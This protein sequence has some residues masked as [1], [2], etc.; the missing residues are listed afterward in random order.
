M[1]KW[2]PFDK[3]ILNAD[4]DE[5]AGAEDAGY[6]VPRDADSGSDLIPGSAQADVDRE[7]AFSSD[8]S[9]LSGS[10]SLNE[11]MSADAD[12][13]WTGAD[14][15][16][17]S[18]SGFG[19]APE[20]GS[21]ASDLSQAPE[22][23]SPASDLSQAP[24][25]GSPAPDL[26]Q[27][28]EAGSFGAD[29]HQSSKEDGSAPEFSQSQEED[30]FGADSGQAPEEN[31]LVSDF[32]QIPEEGNTAPDYSQPQEAG[33]F[34]ADFGQA[35]EE[36]GSAPDFS[37][38]AEN[39][40]G[41][42]EPAGPDGPGFGPEHD[43]EDDEPK[44]DTQTGERLDKPKKKLP[45]MFLTFAV[46]V[47]AVG[48]FIYSV[49]PG[50]LPSDNDVQPKE[51]VETE[52][53]LAIAEHEE[54]SEK[55]AF[56]QTEPESAEP[57][58]TEG[59]SEA[60]FSTVQSVLKPS[61]TETEIETETETEAGAGLQIFEEGPKFSTDGI[62]VS[63]S[64]DVSDLVEEAMPEV[65]SVT[66]ASVQRVWDF[67]SGE[68]EIVQSEAGSGIIIGRDEDYLYIVT[69]GVI[70]AGAQEVTVGF[71]VKMEVSDKLDAEDTIV[72]AEV[73]GIDEDSLLAVI[74][75]SADQVNETVLSL[76]KTAVLG[77]SDRLRPGDNVFAIGN[78]MGRGLS[79]TRGIISAVHRPVK[80]GTSV[81]E[82]IQ[83]DASINYGNYGG[84]LLNDAGEVI[85]I[86]AGKSTEESAEGI[87]FA[88]PSNDAKAAV[89]RILGEEKE[90]PAAAD[91]DADSA[92]E[93]EEEKEKEKEPL[94]LALAQAESETP[95]AADTKE[96]EALAEAADVKE[97]EA[98]TEAV[99]EEISQPETQPKDEKEETIEAAPDTEQAASGKE[100][101]QLGIQVGEFSKEN[102][103]IYRIPEGVVVAEVMNGSGAQAAGLLSGD[104][105]T[106]INDERITGVEQ[107]KK[108]LS[109]YGK[110]DKVKVS[111]IRPDGDS[112]YEESN[113]NYVMVELS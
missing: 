47:L 69:D 51:P 44:F 94:T 90:A 32:S 41:M 16:D 29:F 76:V 78:A 64:L 74:R 92:K 113:E 28:P 108:A 46:S 56:A 40:G 3:N 71:S 103:I 7:G 61:V 25:E 99:P 52:T 18:A 75:V 102:Q 1:A 100:P 73:L 21:P 57:V 20:E 101:G 70:V 39:M 105:I 77:D 86:N 53:A 104:L 80:Y 26:S 60:A 89:G 24:E 98:L 31:D 87:G 58:Q 35:P 82:M 111:Y 84:A 43:F 37:Q 48:A 17:I 85:G 49:K 50:A 106:K 66:A 4:P 54:E 23:G 5:F 55:T 67:F 63:A 38:A 11:G 72:E 34:G 88:F 107:L 15:G 12:K 95:E 42:G 45:A 2:N 10:D 6:G 65:V 96:S 13:V 97:S 14:E 62:T 27:A 68:Q 79:V 93:T 9:D 30:S 19:Q 36:S 109:G 81:H 83:T 8:A 22:E 112:V 110:G 59:E 33:S 91:K